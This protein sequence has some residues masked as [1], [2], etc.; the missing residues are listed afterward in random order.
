VNNT[1]GQLVAPGTASNREAYVRYQS[2]GNSWSVKVGQMYLPFGFRLQD[3]TAF[4]RQLS[5]ISMTTP[6]TGIEFSWEP[7]N[8]ST[9]FGVSNGSAGGPETDTGKEYS[10]QG[11]YVKRNWRLGLAGNFNDSATGDRSVMGVF[12][13][14]KTGPVSW[15]G[16]VDYV[17]DKG[18]SGGDRKLVAGLLEGNWRIRQGH[19][20]KLTAEE[21]DPDRDVDNDAQARYSA[22]YEYTPIQYLQLRLGVRYYS[23]IP[24]NDLQNRRTGFLE[25]HGFY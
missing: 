17:D 1:F 22:V 21:F 16:E 13:G 12:A 3:N 7:G 18:L 23:G 8:W 4:V 2:S 5:G 10:L 19:N 25:L 9:Q 6:D 24:Q 14:L 11:S 15:L 20:F